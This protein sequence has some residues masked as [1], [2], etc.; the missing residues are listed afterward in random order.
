[1]VYDGG[2]ASNTIIWD[3]G[4]DDADADAYDDVDGIDAHARHGNAHGDDDHHHSHVSAD[5]CDVVDAHGQGHGHAH[6]VDAAEDGD[7]VGRDAAEYDFALPTS[8][9]RSYV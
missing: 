1:M 8:T 6:D 9:R 3:D 5:D 2:L 7:D 4:H